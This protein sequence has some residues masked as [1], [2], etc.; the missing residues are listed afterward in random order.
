MEGND[1]SF[2]GGHGPHAERAQDCLG[3]ED[4]TM[5]EGWKTRTTDIK[6]KTGI[7]QLQ[8]FRSP[9]GKMFAAVSRHTIVPSFEAK[10]TQQRYF[11]TQ[12]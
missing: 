6:N 3:E 7:T 2:P 12:V 8:W 5:P 1:A 9:D 10:P 11:G 4:P